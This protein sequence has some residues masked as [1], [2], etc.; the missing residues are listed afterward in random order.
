MNSIVKGSSD[1]LSLIAIKFSRWFYLIPNR[2]LINYNFYRIYDSICIY[3]IKI[4]CLYRIK[5]S[6]IIVINIGRCTIILLLLFKRFFSL[7]L[8]LIL[9]DYIFIINRVN[10]GSL[11][12][13]LSNYSF[14]ISFA[15]FLNSRLGCLLSSLTIN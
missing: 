12:T 8:G 2:F 6:S 14:L 3:W 13:F 15:L 11:S 4:I 1:N 5:Y 7:F 10:F 9:L